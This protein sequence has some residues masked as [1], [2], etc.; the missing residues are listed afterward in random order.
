M[1]IKRN[2]A[3]HKCLNLIWP[4]LQR[5]HIR[6]GCPRNSQGQ[7][8]HQP[9]TR[10]HHGT[11]VVGTKETSDGKTEKLYSV[12]KLLHFRNGAEKGTMIHVLSSNGEETWEP[13]DVIK[14]DIPN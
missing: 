2:E 5:Q 10:T 14:V 11:S 7:S 6:K 1:N 3:K 4:T 12:D 8:Q 13:E 9:H